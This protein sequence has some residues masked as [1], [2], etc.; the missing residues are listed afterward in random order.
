MPLRAVRPPRSASR[1]N[2]C[3]R[4]SSACRNSTFVPVEQSA[5]CPGCAP[6]DREGSKAEELLGETVEVHRGVV[7]EEVE[8]G[9]LAVAQVN[10]DRSPAAK[11]KGSRQ[12]RRQRLP[13]LVPFRAQAQPEARR[14]RPP[15]ADP[16]RP[17]VACCGRQV[18]GERPHRRVKT[19]SL[20]SPEPI[21]TLQIAR[22]PRKPLQV[23]RT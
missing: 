5:E 7:V 20:L 15:L 9:A 4:T 12:V 8:V 21:G 11:V 19:A 17:S 13:D 14:G 23:H 3:G 18:A 1:S 6:G 2:T 10:G 22:A 16:Q